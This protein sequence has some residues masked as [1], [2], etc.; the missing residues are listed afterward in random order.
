M[1]IKLH[2]A[3]AA[4]AALTMTVTAGA[5][6][7]S[8]T[9]SN[10]TIYGYFNIEGSFKGD[11]YGF[12]EIN[13]NN[14]QEP[15]LLYDFPSHGMNPMYAGAGVDGVLYGACYIWNGSM[16]PTIPGDLIAYNIT[17]GR[18]TTIGPWSA[19]N[20]FLKPQDMT[21]DYTTNTMYAMAFDGNG[22][23]LM[24]VNLETGEFENPL[25]IKAA[26]SF[27]TLAASPAGELY[28]IGVD[29]VLYK[30]SKASGTISSVF[31]TGLTGYNFT[32]SMEFDPTSGNIY[33]AANVTDY[34]PNQVLLMEI[35]MQDPSNPSIKNLGQFGNGAVFGSLYIQGA[36]SYDAP[37]V[38]AGLTANNEA[39]K[40]D[41]KLTWTNPSTTF[42]NGQLN[43]LN[44]IVVFRDGEVV[45]TL[46]DAKPGQEM[47]YTDANVSNGEH[48]YDIMAL[49]TG[50]ESMKA[51]VFAYI[52][53][54]SPASVTNV[55]IQG[56]DAYSAAV[57]TWDP[58]TTGLHGG[59]FNSE[60][61]KYSVYRR[62]DNK[63][64]AENITATSITDNSF[65][66]TLQYSY[67]I[68]A[69]NDIGAAPA[70]SSAPLILG[71]PFTV[72]FD[73]TFDQEN[74]T[75]NRWMITDANNDYNT[76]VFNTTAGSVFFG[77]YETAL[78][79]IVS[80][81][82][83][84]LNED[85]DEWIVSGPIAFEAGKEY[86]MQLTVRAISDETLE[87]AFGTSEKPSELN[88]IQT[89][90]IAPYEYEEGDLSARPTYI[91][92]SLPTEGIEVGNIGLHLTTPVASLPYSFLQIIAINV[93]EKGKGGIEGAEID[94]PIVL[95]RMVAG[96]FE[97][98]G[99]F[100]K[101]EFYNI[102]GLKIGE[103]KQSITDLNSYA[104]G[105][106]LAVV[107]TANG[108]V[109]VKFV[110]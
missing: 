43:S 108:P 34:D 53:Q 18:M 68:V 16:S 90:N 66:R 7:I 56:T 64:V 22:S 61:V 106:Y 91:G 15:T 13:T 25:P 37:A 24:T 75:L 81:L 76:W 74:E 107:H 92:V 88:V 21:Y 17:T 19:G 46:T 73:E 110:K 54:D 94:T 104:S 39:G 50:G 23:K 97:V 27:A 77:D 10:R 69:L 99:E 26:L 36:T 1:R 95:T 44:G 101:I 57:L 102:G 72:P 29:G 89:L 100:D 45:T 3:A 4:L 109:T 49:G 70:T 78:E 33:W 80:P 5:A 62:P 28:A 87:V 63:L 71:K 51:T 42:G 55:N 84:D 41:V 96:N 67:D 60:S 83:D 47:T 79:Y 93:Y 48:R 9:E 58:V 52:G 30:I 2:P 86:E 20:E 32:Q 103:S 82:M 31:N 38:V 40:P 65:T 14:L 6:D 98:A 12:A 8:F 11:T 59:D 105:I 35:N 85:A